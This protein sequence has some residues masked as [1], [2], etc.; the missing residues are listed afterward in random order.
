MTKKCLFRCTFKMVLPMR[1]IGI[2]LVK[3]KITYFTSYVYN[4]ITLI[5]VFYILILLTHAVS[6][7]KHSI[8]FFGE[9]FALPRNT[10]NFRLSFTYKKTATDLCRLISKT[11]IFAATIFR[12]HEWI[13]CAY[14]DISRFSYVFDNT[15]EVSFLR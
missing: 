7:I 8:I 2:M 14:V 12:R 4:T 5:K 6:P 11:M 3:Y 9:T 13:N 10:T 1:K 15:G